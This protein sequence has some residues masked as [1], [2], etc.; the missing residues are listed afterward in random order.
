[1]LNSPDS[2]LLIVPPARS[3]CWIANGVTPANCV[4]K[5]P[6]QGVL[7][8]SGG[9]AAS[10]AMPCAEIVNVVPVNVDCKWYGEPRDGEHPSAFG[11]N[12][13]AHAVFTGPGRSALRSK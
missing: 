2:L 13:P 9:T 10:R 7:L 6:S 3:V 8:I 12:V 11:S 4:V 5:R 1:M